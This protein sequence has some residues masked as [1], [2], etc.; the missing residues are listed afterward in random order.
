MCVNVLPTCVCARTRAC[1]PYSCS[2]C[3]GQ[4]RT[5]GFPGMRVS[6]SCEQPCV[7]WKL[8]PGPLQDQWVL[9]PLS[10]PSTPTPVFWCVRE[11]RSLCLHCE[12]FCS[13]NLLHSP[14]LSLLFEALKFLPWKVWAV[15]VCRPSVC[16]CVCCSCMCCCL[17]V[18]L[19][20]KLEDSTFKSDFLWWLKL[21]VYTE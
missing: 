21:S 16:V 11:L 8:N 17:R 13:L 1:V 3:I 18:I 6:N 19:S 14:T 7:F 5:L 20:T 2:A 15:L 10:N 12:Y 9:L 4:K